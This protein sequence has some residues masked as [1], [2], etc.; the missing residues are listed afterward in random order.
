MRG[1]ALHAEVER[2]VLGR[3]HGLARRV[4]RLHAEH[5]IRAGRPPLERDH[6][7]GGA[8][9]VARARRP[10]QGEAMG[11]VHAAHRDVVRHRLGPHVQ[12]ERPLVANREE[13][14]GED[15]ARPGGVEVL[16]PV[17]AEG[18]RVGHEPAGV[19]LVL[20]RAHRDAD[21]GRG[22]AHV[23][24][25]PHHRAPHHRAP[26][27]TLSP[28]VRGRV[29]G[30]FMQSTKMVSKSGCAASETC[31][32]RPAITS[33]RARSASETSASCAPSAAALPT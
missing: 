26:H 29:R 19:D 8:E 12:R 32:M 3:A 28:S 22:N 23:S 7:G 31:S 25:A 10:V 4:H 2:A 1:L 14:V 9:P 6:G 16:G 30:K 17:L 24:R 20:A 15:A 21:G 5:E 18:G 13:R 33:A 11:R 27:P